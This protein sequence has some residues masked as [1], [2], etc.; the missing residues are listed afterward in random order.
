MLWKKDKN[1]EDKKPAKVEPTV[2]EQEKEVSAPGS[3]AKFL[4]T[5]HGILKG[6]Y[7]SEK[8][9]VLNALGQYTFKVFDNATKNEVKK[10]VEKSFEV[11]VKGVK[12]INL[13]RKT[14]NV[15]RHSGFKPGLK[16]AIV[17]LK[18]G[19]VIEQVKL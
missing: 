3:T 19:Y 12:M 18:E 11:K 2:K 10:Q 17:A 9:A 4:P 14:R 8:A 15:G 13:P 6:F 16:K 7:V 1:K 5:G